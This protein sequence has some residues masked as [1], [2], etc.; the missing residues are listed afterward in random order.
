MKG[1][2]KYSQIMDVL[3]PWLVTITAACNG[4]GF[5]LASGNLRLLWRTREE[6]TTSRAWAFLGGT[7][8]FFPLQLRQG[9]IIIS[10]FILLLTHW[11]MSG[12]GYRERLMRFWLQMALTFNIWHRRHSLIYIHIILLTKQE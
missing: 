1:Q 5:P 8:S 11:I 9:A 10:I 6:L 12:A 3:L 7:R 4:R 2:E